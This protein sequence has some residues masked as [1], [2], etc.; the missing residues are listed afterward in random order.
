MAWK[1]VTLKAG[2]RWQG[3]HFYPNSPSNTLTSV[4]LEEKLEANNPVCDNEWEDY[5]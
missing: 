4:A 5:G 1:N 2:Y 3:S